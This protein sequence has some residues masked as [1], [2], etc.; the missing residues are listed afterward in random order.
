MKH[1]NISIKW[2]VFIYMIGFCGILICLL[3]LFQTVY[4][5]R[6]YK[7]IKKKEIDNAIENI[8]TVMDNKDPESDIETISERY[9]LCVLVVDSD[10]NN[11]Y[12]S[13]RNPD[14]I[15]H[16]YNRDKLKEIYKLAAE[17]DGITQINTKD[18][19]NRQDEFIKNSELPQKSESRYDM[20]KLPNM[21]KARNS[22]GIIK[23]KIVNIG[24]EKYAV[25]V[26]CVITPVSATVHTLRIQLVYISIIMIILS[27][28]IAFFLSKFISKPIIKINEQAKVLAKGNFDVEFKESGYREI[29]ELSKTLNYTTQEL[30]KS[31]NLQKE[32][33]ANVSHDLRT[34]LTMITGYGEVMRDLPGENTPE[35]VQVI[36][37]EA[38]R[39]TGLVNDLLD[40]SKIQAGVTGLETKE[41]DITESIK[42]IIERHSKLLEP[43]G[44]NI[45][46]K[47]NENI[48]VDADE[49]KIYQVVYNLIENAV[50]YSYD[51][52]TITVS[53]IKH[54]D[55][56]RIEVEDHGPGIP[57]DKLDSV[58]DR[59]YKID[60]N[61]KRAI[62]GSGLGLSIV[63][64]ILEM[65]GAKYGVDS[66]EGV[67]STFWFELPM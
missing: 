47:Y 16:K 24:G 36:I 41:F 32:L 20:S 59:Y 60:K 64:N 46:F 53:Q 19:M 51:N 7:S 5:D 31:D 12:T 14:C 58:W 11:I 35:N 52:K 10:G 2:K 6:F 42:A 55:N 3:W 57:K 28:L 43:Y 4:L 33:L 65:H 9:Q 38:K 49:F 66:T 30:S 67:G 22:E 26:D 48:I 18:E 13:D 54:R 17:N 56:V 63:K 23:V 29:S 61:H 34:P 44:Y 1:S 40:I 8:V 15:I 45:Y 21:P 27:I 50:N 25:I 62:I 39:L 37:D